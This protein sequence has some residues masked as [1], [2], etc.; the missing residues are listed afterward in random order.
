VLEWGSEGR[1]HC[2]PTEFRGVIQNAQDFP[3]AI[4]A[5]KGGAAPNSWGRR[6]VPNS[7]CQATE[8][9]LPSRKAGLADPMTIRIRMLPN[10]MPH[11]QVA[12]LPFSLDRP[13]Q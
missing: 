11:C 13:T 12:C 4:K 8:R 6:A 10:S 9:T 1:S 5:K 3:I 7:C 2:I